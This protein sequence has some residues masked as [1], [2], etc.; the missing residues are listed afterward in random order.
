MIRSLFFLSILILCTST[1]VIIVGG[2]VSGVTAG[3]ILKSKG[4]N[5]TLLE[6]RNRRGGRLWSDKSKFGYYIDFGGAWIHGKTGNSVYDLAVK[7]KT[8]LFSFSFDDSKYFSTTVSSLLDEE[9]Y[10]VGDAFNAYID[11]ERSGYQ[12][13]EDHPS[14]DLYK[15][16]LES[17]E[18]SKDEK[19]Y[20]D[21]FVYRQN[22]KSLIA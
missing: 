1:D 17:K 16:Y 3:N 7:A 10:N 5:V 15:T 20:L 21:N 2:G 6:A 12:A 18:F 11:S 22:L 9:Y 13:G 8:T 19:C 4:F 14:S